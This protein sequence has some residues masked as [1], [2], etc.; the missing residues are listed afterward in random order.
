VTLTF[1]DS[2]TANLHNENAYGL[3][4]PPGKQGIKLIPI[5]PQVDAIKR[6]FIQ[7]IS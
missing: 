5:K 1:P 7:P 3:S 6:L 4:T 2:V